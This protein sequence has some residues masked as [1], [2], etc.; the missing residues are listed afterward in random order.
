[1]L[2]G[3]PIPLKLKCPDKLSNPVC[4]VVISFPAGNL[5]Y[6]I[7]NIAVIRENIFRETLF[8]WEHLSVTSLLSLPRPK[9]DTVD[10]LFFIEQVTRILRYQPFI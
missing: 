4:K 9:K 6:A 7:D 1:M 3:T 10:A 8:S 2:S 5:Q